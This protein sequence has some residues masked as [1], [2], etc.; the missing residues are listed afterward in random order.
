MLALDLRRQGRHEHKNL[1]RE[2]LNT[3]QHKYMQ[4]VFQSLIFCFVS[5]KR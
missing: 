3:R 2:T 4:N 5:V 1:N